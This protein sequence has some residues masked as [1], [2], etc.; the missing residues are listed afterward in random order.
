MKSHKKNE[1]IDNANEP[2][3]PLITMRVFYVL[4]A[5][6][7]PFIANM[8]QYVNVSGG[9]VEAVNSLGVVLTVV[10]L[11]MAVFTAKFFNVEEE[12]SQKTFNENNWRIVSSKTRKFRY[13]RHQA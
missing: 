9:V 7:T 5:V 2:K 3:N 12:K 4:G 11:I 10:F 1:S 13:Y 8:I 6:I